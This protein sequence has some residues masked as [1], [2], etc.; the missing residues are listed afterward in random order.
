MEMHFNTV[1]VWNDQDRNFAPVPERPALHT[2][3]TLSIE[4]LGLHF[5]KA[6]REQTHS[7]EQLEKLYHAF[8]FWK[9]FDYAYGNL[10]FIFRPEEN[11]GVRMSEFAKI[12]EV[13]R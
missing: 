9:A 4:A 13:S 6:V 8:V 7:P 12:R 1:K 2:W 11:D 3:S 5:I 10:P